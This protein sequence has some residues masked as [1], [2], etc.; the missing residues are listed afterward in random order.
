MNVSDV[1]RPTYSVLPQGSGVGEGSW[2]GL[3]FSPI[4]W[5]MVGCYCVYLSSFLYIPFRSNLLENCLKSCP[6]FQKSRW[7]S[8]TLNLGCAFVHYYFRQHLFIL[9]YWILVSEFCKWF[10]PSLHADLNCA[11]VFLS[12][13]LK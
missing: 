9:Y 2:A 12:R 13:A 4:N 8:Y 10:A 7:S 3:S 1:D 11:L 6:F 5:P